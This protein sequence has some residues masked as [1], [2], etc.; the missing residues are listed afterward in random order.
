MPGQRPPWSAPSV[1]A[2]RPRRRCRTR[3]FDQLPRHP[4]RDRQL[5]R[6]HRT[7]GSAV[8][9]LS[10]LSGIVIC[11]FH[12]TRPL[13]PPVYP[14]PHRARKHSRD[15]LFAGPP[16]LLER[17]AITARLYR[18]GSTN[19]ALPNR[20]S[21]S[22]APLRRRCGEPPSVHCRARKRY[23]RSV[24]VGAPFLSALAHEA[25]APTV[26]AVPGFKFCCT[27]SAAYARAQT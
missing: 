25:T 1:A 2:L 17:H 5:A 12:C 15:G 24:L 26:A 14:V 18:R 10:R 9:M 27:T 13:Q 23:S 6:P 7:V 21:A 11:P 16:T 20:S 19:A 3:A 4:S 22:R 8:S